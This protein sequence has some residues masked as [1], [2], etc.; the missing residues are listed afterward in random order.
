MN[1]KETE[2]CI[3]YSFQDKELLIRALTHSSY[4]NEKKT[5]NNERLEFLGDSVLSVVVSE[6]IYRQ[7][8]DIN[9]GKLTQVRANLVCEKSLAEFAR[10]IKLGKLIYLGH[11]E[12]ISG[13]RNRASVVSD[14]F[15]AVL[16][17]IYLDGG[18]NAAKK[19]LLDLI[20]EDIKSAIL[21]KSTKDFKT[22]LQEQV[23]K[24]G[25]FHTVTYNTVGESGEDHN[26]KFRVAVLVDD[27]IIEYGEGNS[28]KEA[29]QNAA[30]AVLKKT[31]E[32]L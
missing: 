23:Q 8:A 27:K 10:R 11:G 29:E 21:K 17:A 3:G 1:I 30:E 32:T 31:H 9:E 13:G 6:Y 19:W 5:L 2:N 28:K 20:E 15:E 22:R 4:A 14:A 26:K 16:A 25:S 7:Y 18:M 24:K 12:E